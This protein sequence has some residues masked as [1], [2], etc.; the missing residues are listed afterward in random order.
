MIFEPSFRLV[1]RRDER[2]EPAWSRDQAAVLAQVSGPLL[3][4]GGPGTGKTRLLIEKVANRVAAGTSLDHIIVCT[5]S[6][7]AAQRLRTQIVRRV[8]GAHLAP[9][10]LTVHAL[11]LTLVRRYTD[12]DTWG[13]LRLLR[14]PEQE[15][16][17]RELLAG[18][19]TSGWPP[20]L[21]AA[22]GTRAFVAQLRAA[23]AHARQ[24][25]LDPDDLR[26]LAADD[27][28]WLV[29]ADFFDEYLT[30]LDFESAVD[31]AEL[32]HRARLLLTEPDVRASLASHVSAVYCDEF[33]ELDPAQRELLADVA[34][35][36]G[37]LVAFADPRQSIF[38]FRGADGGVA[39]WFEERWGA[40]ARLDLATNHRGG[41]GLVDCWQRVADRL[42]AADAPPPM[43][44]LSGSS[45]V[46]A[47]LYDDEIAELT[48]IAE[49]LR[50]AHLREG[51]PWADCAVIA[52]MGR[53]EL[54]LVAH[55]LRQFGVPVE[56]AGDEI[57]LAE[58]PAVRTLL[59]ALR[60]LTRASIEP[61][62]AAALL[63]SPLGGLDSLRLRGAARRLRAERGLTCAQA[64]S[65][66]GLLADDVDDS[67]VHIRRLGQLLAKA[68]AEAQNNASV[69]RVV[70]TLW[71]GT[72]WPQQLREAALFGGDARANGHLDAV[73]ELVDHAQR[74]DTLVGLGGIE[75]F[76]SS[77]A[78]QQIPA[79]TGRESDPRG[80]GVRLLTAHRAKGEQFRV[81]FVMGLVEGRWPV[82]T[83]RGSLLE[84]GSLTPDGVSGVRP[85]SQ[86]ADERRLFYVACTRATE[87]LVVSG[88]RGSEGGGE[89]RFLS[90][91]GAPVIEVHGRV[92]RPLTLAALVGDLRQVSADPSA[93]P[94]LR[95]AAASRLAR[96]ADARD[97]RGRP[98]ASTA[99]PASWWGLG[100]VSG[101]RALESEP[102]RFSGSDLA[103]IIECPRRWFL[104]RRAYAA[105]TTNTAASL[106]STIHLLA[107]RALG[108]DVTLDELRAELD[109]SWGD[110]FFDAPWVAKAERIAADDA[111]ARLL[112][113]QRAHTSRQ[114]LGTE[115]AFTVDVEAGGE[116][117]SLRGSV[118]RLELDGDRLKIIDFKTS[119]QAPPAARVVTHEQLG[120]YQL[121]AQQGAFDDLAPGVRSVADA[122]LVFLR[123]QDGEAP[124]PK[125][126]RQSSLDDVPHPGG[127]HLDHPTWVHARLAE[128]ASI[129][130]RGEFPAIACAS[131]RFCQF[132]RGCPALA[133]VSEDAS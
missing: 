17:L 56:V 15:A 133:R 3:V 24:L 61:D 28:A 127:E 84:P 100:G 126:L 10:V 74:A 26:A 83:K 121:A 44:S 69:H 37:E 42:S 68:R 49:Q 67:L 66:P 115:V 90:E 62:D 120:L 107:Q 45:A 105:Q 46:E 131:C 54:S 36:G 60:V 80:R 118:D 132:Q 19:D 27:P 39:R 47:R 98:V 2:V 86:V 11:A 25:G 22:A 76:L 123:V 82:L 119:R 75:T 130:R 48:H 14:A 8:G 114:V 71:Q 113:W 9:R 125:V 58:Q 101:G 112:A 41:A 65:E 55:T 128:A 38:G 110:L 129:V 53:G 117:I 1:D 73:T 96:L 51:V 72:Q 81:V 30:V 109:A 34:G 94:G 104:A 91:L 40:S 106:G 97:R 78:E 7:A 43:A 5:H 95:R 85:N 116:P 32:V 99:D 122:E 6:R 102:L 63:V 64:L 59:A 103:D 4:L 18:H 35:V 79:D 57:A 20:E 70:W 29:A 124:W 12:S 16:R 93:E 31:Y 89:S 92:Q 77:V 87:R 23:L 108:D 13:E 88:S 21:A 33:A 50:A 52:R 111:L